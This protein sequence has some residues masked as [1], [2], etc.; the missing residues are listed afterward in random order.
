MV[1]MKKTLLEIVQDILNDLDSDNVNSIDDTIE[2]TQVANI[3]A[4]TYFD[5]I[6]TRVIPEHFELFR[7]TALSDS[8]RPNYM[9]LPDN[10]SNIQK[11]EYNKS[12]NSEQEYKEIHWREPLDFLRHTGARNSA[13]SDVK[14]VLDFNGSTELLI[15]TDRMPHM[16]TTFDNKHVVMDSHDLTIDSTLQASKSRGYGE[17]IPTVTLVDTF[18]FDIETKMFPYLIAEAK[19]RSFSIL[20][21]TVDQ[22]VEQAARRHMTRLQSERYRF[23]TQKPRNGRNYGRT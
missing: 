13:S 1:G 5:L 11:I 16:Y 23:D 12:S 4:Q 2:A 14:T 10:V 6:G 20:H 8:E 19:S 21:K 9:A 3:V 17:L 22:K 7:L 18:T 15:F